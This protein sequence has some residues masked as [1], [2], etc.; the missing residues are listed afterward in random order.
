[1]AQCCK[2]WFDCPECHDENSN[3]PLSHN[4]NEVV[5]AC[6]ACHKPFWKDMSV[7]DEDDEV[8]PHCQNRFVVVAVTPEYQVATLAEE[9]LNERMKIILEEASDL[10]S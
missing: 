4:S 5:F 6:K 2:K 7:F 8:C 1:M 3:H 9:Y 10:N